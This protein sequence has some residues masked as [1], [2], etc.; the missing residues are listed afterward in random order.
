MRRAQFFWDSGSLDID[1]YD[2][3]GLTPIMLYTP[4]YYRPDE[5][6]AVLNWFKS[7]GVISTKSLQT[8]GLVKIKSSSIIMDEELP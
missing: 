6:I 7:K 1:G 3:H 5:S 8:I 2:E 4:D